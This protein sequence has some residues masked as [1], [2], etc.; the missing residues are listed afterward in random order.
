M[1]REV[2]KPGLDARVLVVLDEDVSAR[3]VKNLKAKGYTATHLADAALAIAVFAHNP[4]IEV[5]EDA[6]HFTSDYGLYVD[7]HCIQMS[8][9]RWQRISCQGYDP[10]AQ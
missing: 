5:D 10:S 1:A 3:I 8:L 4:N 2:T 6:A 7:L 9:T